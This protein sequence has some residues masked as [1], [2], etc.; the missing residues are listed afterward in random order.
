MFF[1]VI[2]HGALGLQI[3]FFV[4]LEVGRLTTGGTTRLA[5]MRFEW[6]FSFSPA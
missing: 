5:V 3:G 6:T 4:L 2:V 1:S